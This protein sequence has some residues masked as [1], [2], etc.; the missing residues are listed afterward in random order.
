LS[1][2]FLTTEAQ[3]SLEAIKHYSLQA[4]GEKRTKQYLLSIQKRFEHLA[5][6]PNHGKTRTDLFSD[7]LCYS[8]F[9]E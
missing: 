6:N 5:E 3:Q 9:E 7:W 1:Q 8:Y 4:F 2:Y